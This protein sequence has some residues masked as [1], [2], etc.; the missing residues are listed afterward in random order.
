[1]QIPYLRKDVHI[2]YYVQ[3]GHCHL[4][5]TI[6]ANMPSVIISETTP[7]LFSALSKT[8]LLVTPLQDTSTVTSMSGI[9]PKKNIFVLLK[10][11]NGRCCLSTLNLSLGQRIVK[12]I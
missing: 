6:A 1:M 11:A 10:D 2:Y 8:A 7:N 4:Q 9:A 12:G 3:V 5:L